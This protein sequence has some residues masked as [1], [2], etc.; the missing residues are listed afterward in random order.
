MPFCSQCGKQVSDHD[1]FCAKCGARQ[2]SHAGAGS[3]ASAG[4]SLSGI[5]PKTASILCYIPGLGWIASVIVLASRKFRTD[6]T[7][8]FHAFQGLYLFVA[9]LV[10]GIV[11]DPVGFPFHRICDLLQL[12]IIVAEVVMIVKLA[13][14]SMNFELPLFGELAHRSAE[15]K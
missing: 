8:R 15:G 6:R 14:G 13:Q 7:V 12:G 2:P 5:S 1:L 4:N 10:V 3:A 9:S 11:L